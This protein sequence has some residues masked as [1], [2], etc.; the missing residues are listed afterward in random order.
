MA[1][2][3]GLSGAIFNPTPVRD[4]TKDFALNRERKTKMAATQAKS[5]EDFASEYNVAIPNELPVQYTPDFMDKVNQLKDFTGEVSTM[6]A[7]ERQKHLPKLRNM[8]KSLL[9]YGKSAILRNGTALAANKMLDEDKEGAFGEVQR[10]DMSGY[11]DGTLNFNGESNYDENGVLMMGDMTV[12]EALQS[13]TF[14]QPIE[15]YDLHKDIIDSYQSKTNDGIFNAESVRG[16]VN[17]TRNSPKQLKQFNTFLKE[18]K[19]YDDDEIVAVMNNNP[20]KAYSDFVEYVVR[21]KKAGRS[22][23]PEKTDTDGG[24]LTFNWG[25]GGAVR[26]LKGTA[27]EEPSSVDKNTPDV[28]TVSYV[29]DEVK[30]T[31][32]IDVIDEDSDDKDAV[33]PNTSTV[34]VI[35]LQKGVNNFNAIITYSKGS[36]TDKEKVIDIIPLS[37]TQKAQMEGNLKIPSGDLNKYFDAKIGT[38]SSPTVKEEVVREEDSIKYL[39]NGEEYTMQ[40]IKDAYGEDFDPNGY[41]GFELIK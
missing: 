9:V 21:T 31:H 28:P 22:E 37:A 39:F 19:G 15:E 23:N 30:I 16:E 1:D 6:S 33:K 13:R 18:Q 10:G 12:G 4:F 27:I 5:A 17:D 40:E 24:G 26:K 38:L 41:E 8:Q 14:A 11:I 36:G 20:D 2:P 32:T 3:R 35:G 25:N 34:S 29:P 7:A